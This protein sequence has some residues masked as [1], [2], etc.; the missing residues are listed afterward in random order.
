MNVNSAQKILY[1]PLLTSFKKK[2]NKT[3]QNPKLYER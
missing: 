1:V 2:K 3:H